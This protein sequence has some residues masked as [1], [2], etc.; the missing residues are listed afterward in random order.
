MDVVELAG[1]VVR[2]ARFLDRINYGVLAR[3]NVHLRVDDGRNYLM[4]TPR[5][6]DVIT[7]DVIHPVFAGSGNLYSVEYFRLMRRVLNPGGLVLQWVAGTE[8]E[9]K[10]IARTFLSVFPGTTAWV[11]GGLLVGSVEP[12][13]LRRSD[14]EWKLTLPGRAQGLHDLNVETFDALLAAFTAGP[15]ELAAFVGPGDLLTDDRP[16]VEYF[17]SLPRAGDVDLTPLKSDRRRVRVSR[18]SVRGLQGRSGP[19][20]PAGQPGPSI[21]I[22]RRPDDESP[23]RIGLFG[24]PQPSRTCARQREPFRRLAAPDAAFDARF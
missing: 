7:A 22:P 23:D 16:V 13:R 9:Y 11:A 6:Y 21:R 14:F 5:R 19:K 24:P 12:L 18:P 10:T 20:L 3:P 8:A 15:D 17:L 1:S 4:L 2:G